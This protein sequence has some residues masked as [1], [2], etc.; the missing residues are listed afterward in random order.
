MSL[1]QLADKY[2]ALSL[3]ERVMIALGVVVAIVILWLY[4]VSDPLR[5][6]NDES[7][8]RIDRL[9]TQITALTQQQAEL[10]RQKGEDP[11]AELHERLAKLEAALEEVETDL[12]RRFRGLIDPHQMAQVLED[13]LINNERLQLVS[14]KSLGSEAVI[15]AQA[16]GA[17][18]A[19]STDKGD[20]QVAVY[21]HGVEIAFRG[22]YLATLDYL[23]SLQ[24]LPWDF[25]WE[26]VQLQVEDYP[27]AEVT[28][29]VYTLSLKRGWIGV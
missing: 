1:Q 26:G 15:N 6:A 29:T 22:S 7:Q 11:N 16:P 10:L 27:N 20:E 18:K 25:Y 3:R 17:D 2:N 5:A 4:L 14:V 19:T 13:L 8:R 23:Q 9:Q 24:S 12:R 28:I 21:R